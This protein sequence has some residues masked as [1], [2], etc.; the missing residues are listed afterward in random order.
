MVGYCYGMLTD[1]GHHGAQRM[2]VIQTF[3]IFRNLE[4]SYHL[5]HIILWI[6]R[7]RRQTFNKYGL[8]S[9]L[10]FVIT[11]STVFSLPAIDLEE[12]LSAVSCSLWPERQ[13]KE[14]REILKACLRLVRERGDHPLD[15]LS[16]YC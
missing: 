1:C 9:A 12:T 4:Y 14:S 8:T 11:N 13:Y 5:T 7:I 6:G 10:T 3:H 2:K 16:A 15:S